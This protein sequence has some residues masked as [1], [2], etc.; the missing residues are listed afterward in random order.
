MTHAPPRSSIALLL[1][2]DYVRMAFCVIYVSLNNYFKVAK[3]DSRNIDIFSFNSTG[4]YYHSSL[5]FILNS[6]F[7]DHLWCILANGR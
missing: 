1:M 6:F 3:Q 4:V 2:S 5:W 7:V